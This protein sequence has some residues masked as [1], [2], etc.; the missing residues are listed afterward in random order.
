MKA[1]NKSPREI[2][3]YIFI[4]LAIL[5]AF[6]IM[7]PSGDNSTTAVEYS[8]L[9]RLFMNERVVYFQIDNGKVTAE[10]DAPYGDSGHLVVTH[11]LLDV[12]L[13]HADFS[14]YINDSMRRNDNFNYNLLP[15]MRIP[16]W[17]SILPYVILI[18]VFVFIW[19]SMMSRSG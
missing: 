7:Y 12:G 14:N 19:H 4:V 15:G 16:W 18:A 1:K 10:L 9:R 8:E 6:M 2:G 11:D 5:I 3:F 13:F 17:V